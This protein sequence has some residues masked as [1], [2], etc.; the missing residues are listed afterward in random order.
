MQIFFS[1]FIYNSSFAT[2][3]N[4]QSHSEN[5]IRKKALHARSSQHDAPMNKKPVYH[6]TS[7]RAFNLLPKLVSHVRADFPCVTFSL[8]YF[9]PDQILNPIF[10]QIYGV[11]Y[12]LLRLGQPTAKPLTPFAVIK[13]SH[14]YCLPY[15]N[16]RR[17]FRMQLYSPQ[18]HELLF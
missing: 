7:I 14:C 11:P 1:K 5:S 17:S 16:L 6:F 12:T 3:A 2:T 13:R 15:S 9:H 18:P 8:T 10:F 4:R